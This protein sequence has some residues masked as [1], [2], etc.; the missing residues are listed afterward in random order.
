MKNGDFLNILDNF[1]TQFIQIFFESYLEFSH[2]EQLSLLQMQTLE[3]LHHLGN[4]DISSIS[5]YLKVTPSAASQMVERLHRDG[6]VIRTEALKDRRNKVVALSPKG[7]NIIERRN[8]HRRQWMAKLIEAI[9][10]DSYTE[11]GQ[12]LQIIQY[13]FPNQRS[14]NENDGSKNTF[15]TP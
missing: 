8:Q 10:T 11:L 1:S 9:P 12:A 14:E 13:Q 5:R 4:C 15:H 3:L 6:L 7:T 2:Q